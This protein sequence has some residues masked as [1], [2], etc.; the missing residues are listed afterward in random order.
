MFAVGFF[1]LAPSTWFSITDFVIQSA[2]IFEAYF[3]KEHKLIGFPFTSPKSN[4]FST[5]N[6]LEALSIL[7]LNIINSS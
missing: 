4:L 3:C 2:V 5:C 6:K 7:L 1:A